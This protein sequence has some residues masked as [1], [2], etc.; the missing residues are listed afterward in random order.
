MVWA[1]VVSGWI[2][3][4]GLSIGFSTEVVIGFST[5]VVMG[6]S[7]VV[8]AGLSTTWVVVGRGAEI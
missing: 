3:V 5:E 7:E 1:L 8:G 4:V 6:F 2:V